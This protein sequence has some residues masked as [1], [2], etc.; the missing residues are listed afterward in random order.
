MG[1]QVSATTYQLV[2]K[3][4]RPSL[5]DEAFLAT[6]EGELRDALGSAVEQEGRDVSPKEIILFMLTPDPRATF[7]KARDVLEQ[8]GV[9]RGVS[10]GYRL[11]GGAKFTSIWPLRTTRKFTLK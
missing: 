2:I 3:L 11:V 4:W 6:L 10:A 1:R 8:A 9:T 5:E 7:R